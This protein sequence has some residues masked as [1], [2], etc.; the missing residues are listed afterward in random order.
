[1][2]SLF[3]CRSCSY[4]FS[5]QLNGTIPPEL[6]KLS[7]LSTLYNQ[8]SDDQL[9]IDIII[10]DGIASLRYISS[11]QLT[12]TIP[13]ELGNTK[14]TGMYVQYHIILL[15]DSIY[16][17]SLL[18]FDLTSHRCA[19]PLVHFRVV[20]YFHTNQLN[21]T[22]PPQLGNLAQLQYMYSQNFNVPIHNICQV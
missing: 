17:M 4:L 15:D 14:L 2:L 19:L 9:I 21:G 18:Q 12:G 6:G 3:H 1:M 5:N 11:N 20:S 8:N 22:I 13:P 7:L 16:L 10:F